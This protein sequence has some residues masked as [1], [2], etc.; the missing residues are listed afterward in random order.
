MTLINIPHVEPS[1]F[2]NYL[3]R[4]GPLFETFQRVRAENQAASS[5][6]FQKDKD[7]KK[8]DELA[9]IIDSTGPRSPALARQ[10]SAA[11]LLSPIES[12]QPRRRSSGYARRRANEPTPLSTIPNV[13]F[14]ENFQLENPRTFDVV[15]ERAEIVRPPPGSAEEKNASNGAA[16]PPRKALATNAILQEKLS[17]YMDTVEVHLISSISSASASFF[18]ALGSLKELQS[19]AE[20]SVEKIKKLRADLAKLD[21]DMAID[22]LKVANMRRRR[23][24][25]RKLGQATRQVQR[26]VDE[27]KRCEELVD[28]GEY[29]TAADKMH[30]VDRLIAGEQD[31]VPPDISLQDGKAQEE[32][33][34]ID[35]RGL[36]ALQGLSDGIR[37]LQFRIGKGYEVRFLEALLSDLRNHVDR[38]PVRDTLRRWANASQRARGDQNRIQVGPPAYLE[39]NEQLRKDLLVSLDGLSKSGQTAQATAAF[40]EAIMKEMKSLIRRHLPSSSDDDA[41]S[42][43]SVSTR[44][45]KQLSQQEKSAILARNLRALDDDA[46]EELLINLYTGTSEALRRLGVQVKV[47]LDVTSGFSSGTTSPPRSPGFQSIEGQLKSTNG[48]T[49]HLQEELTQALDMSSLLGQAVDTAQTQISRILKVRTEQSNRLPLE[50]F[51]RYFTLNRMF[52]DE[53]EAVSGRSGSVLKN[54]VNTQ[55][56]AFVHTLGDTENQRVAQQLDTDQWE[57]KD[58]TEEDQAVLSRILQ[59]MTSDPAVWTKA[60]HVWEPISSS[61]SEPKPPEAN[62]ATN[63]TTA[64]AS[65]PTTR[66]AYIDETRYILVA[67]AISILRPIDTFLA[68]VASIPSIAPTAVQALADVLRTFNSRSCQ[69]ILGAGAT[70]SA[71]LKNITTKHLA[72]ASQALSFV[73][74][75]IPYLREGVRRHL[76]G[77]NQAAGQVLQDFDKVKRLCQDHQVGIHDKLVEIMTSR[78]NAHVTAMKKISFDDRAASTREGV[79]PYMETLTKE[80]GTLYR[81]LGRHLNEGEVIGIMAGVAAAYK[82]VWAKAFAEVEVFT[83]EGKD[84]YVCV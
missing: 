26:I 36:K 43:T 79:S 61:S 40:R 6:I 34:L 72:L 12:P 2:Q 10:N 84:R 69:L 76:G 55:I 53:C 58:F 38:V 71:G 62:G 17:W 66:P 33:Q 5:Q 37:L 11:S 77:G 51:L 60:T 64:P 39:T 46:A 15:S 28:Y 49:S 8:N 82:D 52:A 68:L 65:K 25:V 83:K 14:E 75:L 29:D 13:Y 54:I 35:L 59:S 20:D 42:V 16:L 27:V 18:A 74:A 9:G 78:A 45:G 19:E 24:N 73:I 67:S 57:A 48:R 31:S 21:E 30:E 32:D 81:V 47:L 80:T 22:G 23:E 44:G 7:A 56:N 3:S 4:I 63:G 1:A 50:R 41:E 70:R